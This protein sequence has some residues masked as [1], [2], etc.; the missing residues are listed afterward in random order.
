MKAQVQLERKEIGIFSI[1]LV[2]VVLTIPFSA[3][4]N[5]WLIGVFSA[6][7]MYLLFKYKSFDTQFL[8]FCSAAIFFQVV[9]FL[10]LI[11]SE[12]A[13]PAFKLIEAH[14][15]ILVFPILLCATGVFWNQNI[16]KTSLIAFACAIFFISVF[17]QLSLLRDL[18]IEQKPLS[19][20][21][22]WRNSNNALSMRVGLHPTY[23]SMYVIF[24][25]A[26]VYEFFLAGKNFSVRSIGAY[27][28]ITYL[29][30]VT[31]HL[32]SKISV[33]ILGVVL[34]LIVLDAVINYDIKIL[35]FLIP[36]SMVC[37]LLFSLND[38]AVT[39]RFES[40]YVKNLLTHFLLGPVNPNDQRALVWHA[41]VEILRENYV[42]GV[43]SGDVM[44]SLL[45]KYEQMGASELIALKLDTHNQ[46]LGAILR[47]GIA[48][49]LALIA[50]YLSGIWDVGYKN[51]LYLVFILIIILTSLTENI[52]ERQ[53]GAVFF[54]VIG[55]ILYR[56]CKKDK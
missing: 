30:V 23:L 36:V 32:A 42:F 18:I 2:A 49:L 53:K 11:N 21:F 9:I 34:L 12:Y 47:N 50:V 17:I 5:A 40:S 19:D 41:T 14:Y 8:V 13:G 27:L 39:S 37:G 52:L 10:G 26:V 3:N 25:A 28:V 48:G 24:S 7:N 43:G 35:W 44:H 16:L 20:F 4:L 38:F 51:R 33:G 31:L 29:V 22:Y 54:G 55:T 1:S 56:Y 46:F 15:P 45:Q 6:F